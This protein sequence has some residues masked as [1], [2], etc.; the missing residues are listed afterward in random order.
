MTDETTGQDETVRNQADRLWDNLKRGLQDGAEIAMSKA[1]ELT[2]V[3]RARLDVAAAKTRLSRL[4][5][6]LGSLVFQM[7]EGG[8]VISSDDTDIES[9]RG[10]IRTAQADLD[11]A[12]SA[13]CDVRR[14][15][16]SQD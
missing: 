16:D 14:T 4:Q 6:E 5:A 15:H 12:E 13:H 8:Q 9:L 10:Q 7:L 2:Q 1:E 3:G 11:G